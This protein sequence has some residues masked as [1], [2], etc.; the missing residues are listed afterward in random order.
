MEHLCRQRNGNRW[1]S[2]HIESSRKLLFI[3]AQMR[4]GNISERIEVKASL[5]VEFKHLWVDNNLDVICIG[6]TWM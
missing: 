4:E 6:Q 5:V 3:P 2:P 1:K